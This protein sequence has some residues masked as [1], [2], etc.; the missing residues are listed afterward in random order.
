ML[1]CIPSPHVS[2]HLPETHS[3]HSQSIAKYSFNILE[4]FVSLQCEKLF[5]NM[6]YVSS[7]INELRDLWK[8]VYFL[9]F[10]L[11]ICR[12]ILLLDPVECVLKSTELSKVSR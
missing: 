8:D 1:V 12:A 2:E 7:Y 10:G 6:V 4:L 11:H 9:P 3:L 5:S